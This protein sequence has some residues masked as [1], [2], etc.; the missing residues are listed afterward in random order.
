MIWPVTSVAGEELSS[1]VFCCWEIVET[2]CVYI[3]SLFFYLGG[4]VLERPVRS[5]TRKRSISLFFIRGQGCRICQVHRCVVPQNTWRNLYGGCPNLSP[6]APPPAGPVSPFS[7]SAERESAIVFDCFTE[8]RPAK[9]PA[10]PLPLAAPAPVFP[11]DFPPGAC[12]K[13]RGFGPAL[14][15]KFRRED[16]IYQVG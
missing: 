1:P 10:K 4:S 3:L 6:S 15:T 5:Q 2:R 14:V 9:S 16:G 7:L 12:V 13:T 11:C 8:S